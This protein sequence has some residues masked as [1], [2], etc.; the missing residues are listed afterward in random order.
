MRETSLLVMLRF[1]RKLSFIKEA[2]LRRSQATKRRAKSGVGLLA[3]RRERSFDALK[4]TKP[5]SGHLACDGQKAVIPVLVA[6]FGKKNKNKYIW[7]EQRSF[8]LVHS[9]FSIT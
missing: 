1:W 9:F 3:L 2:V 7:K 8:F 5:E 6:A 4:T